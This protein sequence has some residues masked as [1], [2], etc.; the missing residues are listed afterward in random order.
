MLSHDG[1]TVLNPSQDSVSMVANGVERILELQTGMSAEKCCPPGQVMGIAHMPDYL[2]KTCM[3]E[4]Q[5]GGRGANETL[6]PSLGAIS[7]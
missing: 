6:I 5:Q 7:S 2:H 4:S 3:G 1:M